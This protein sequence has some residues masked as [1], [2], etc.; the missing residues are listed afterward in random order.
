MH[1]AAPGYTM[2][3]EKMVHFQLEKEVAPGPKYHPDMAA[4]QP[5]SNGFSMGLARKDD[6]DE[7]VPGPGAYAIPRTAL[8]DKGGVFGAVFA[9]K[10]TE[11]IPGPG[12]YQVVLKLDK[13]GG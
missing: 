12:S 6:A 7:Q 10:P 3:R 13:R 5:G 1:E 4:V 8:S 2:G 11:P 9:D